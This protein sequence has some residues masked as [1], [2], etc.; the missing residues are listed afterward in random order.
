MTQRIFLCTLALA[1]TSGGYAGVVDAQP[2]PRDPVT[3]DPA[4]V[5]SVLRY[6][7]M[8]QGEPVILIQG[9]NLPMRMW[10]AQVRVSQR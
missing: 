2:V 10:D 4:N 6:E 9:A 8:G 3:L 5:P 1:L 7:Q